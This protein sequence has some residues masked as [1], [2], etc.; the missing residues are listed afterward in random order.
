MI[1][2]NENGEAVNTCKYEGNHYDCQPYAPPQCEY[3]RGYDA[4]KTAAVIGTVGLG[5]ILMCLIM[6]SINEK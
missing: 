1:Y 6:K 4:G 2:L 5:A 3:N